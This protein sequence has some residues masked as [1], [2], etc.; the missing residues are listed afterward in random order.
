MPPVIQSVSILFVVILTVKGLNFDKYIQQ[1]YSKFTAILFNFFF[2]KAIGYSRF[3]PYYIRL[4]E[5]LCPTDFTV[6]TTESNLGLTSLISKMPDVKLKLV[7][8][9]VH[10]IVGISNSRNIVGV[11]NSVSIFLIENKTSLPLDF[12]HQYITK[13]IGTTNDIVAQSSAGEIFDMWKQFIDGGTATLESTAYRSLRKILMFVVAATISDVADKEKFLSNFTKYERKT[14]DNTPIANSMLDVF[15]SINDLIT[16]GMQYL[17]GEISFQSLLHCGSSYVEWYESS[18]R[19]IQNVNRYCTEPGYTIAKDALSSLEKAIADGNQIIA[20][21]AGT[22]NIPYIQPQIIR[23]EAAKTKLVSK[24]MM[25]SSRR[26]PLGILIH[27]PPKVGKSFTAQ[28]IRSSYKNVFKVENPD[29]ITFNKNAQDDYFTGMT[30]STKI[31]VMDDVASLNPKSNQP[32]NSLRELLNIISPLPY[33]PNMAAV[34]E[35]GTVHCLVDVVVATTNTRHLNVRDNFSNPNAFIRRFPYVIEPVVKPEFAVVNAKSVDNMI[36]SEKVQKYR[37]AHPGELFDVSLYRVC[38]PLIH[39]KVRFDDIP[40]F[41]KLLT[42]V[43][44]YQFIKEKIEGHKKEQDS[45]KEG[46]DIITC[47]ECIC[48]RSVPISICPDCH[49]IDKKLWNKTQQ[50]KNMLHFKMDN[51]YLEGVNLESYRHLYDRR[52]HVAEFNDNVAQVSKIDDS[53]K[54]KKALT[55]LGDVASSFFSHKFGTYLLSREFAVFLAFVGSSAFIYKSLYKNEQVEEAPVEIK[56]N[57]KVWEKF[58]I[59]KSDFDLTDRTIHYT[60]FFKKLSNY[61]IRIEG[62]HMGYIHGIPLKGSVYIFPLHYFDGKLE[63]KYTI[64]NY[65]GNVELKIVLT[66]GDFTI[67]KAMDLAFVKIYDVPPAPDFSKYFITESEVPQ[68][69]GYPA[70]IYIWN[71]KEEDCEIRTVNLSK[72]ENINYE[73]PSSSLKKEKST[74]ITTV[75]DGAFV[76][77]DCGSPIIIKHKNRPVIV[78]FH[79]AYSKQRKK[80]FGAILAQETFPDLSMIVAQGSSM[81]GAY[82]VYSSHTNQLHEN[83]FLNRFPKNVHQFGSIQNFARVRGKGSVQKTVIHDIVQKHW[84]LEHDEYAQPIMNPKTIDGVFQ[85]PFANGFQHCLN[86]SSPIPNDFLFDTFPIIFLKHV[87]ESIEGKFLKPLTLLEAVNGIDGHPYIKSM[88][89]STSMGYPYRGPKSNFCVLI[90][91]EDPPSF[92]QRGNVYVC[93]DDLSDNDSELS[94]CSDCGSYLGSVYSTG[95]TT[96]GYKSNDSTPPFTSSSETSDGSYEF[97]NGIPR[98]LYKPNEETIE[99]MNYMEKEYREGRRCCP[100][101]NTCLKDEALPK[102][103]QTKTRIFAASMFA[104]NLLVRKYFLPIVALM[105]EDPILWCNSVG[106]NCRGSAWKDLHNHL[107]KFGK[108][109]LI[110]GDYSKYDK[111]MAGK[112]ILAALSFLIIIAKKVGYSYD[113]LRIMRAMSYD[114]AYPLYNTNGDLHMFNGSNASGNSLTVDINCIVNV[115]YMMFAYSQFYDE[116]E[117]FEKVAPAMYGD[118]NI[119]GISRDRPNYNHTSISKFFATIGIK[120]TMADKNAISVPYRGIGDVSYLKRKFLKR[121][122]RILAPLDPESLFKSLAYRTSIKHE[123]HEHTQEVLSN[124][125]IEAYAYKDTKVRDAIDKIIEESPYDI[126][127]LSEDQLAQYYEL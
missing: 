64:T 59:P 43:E 103:K 85:D 71:N 9:L 11:I 30:S 17:S 19:Q 86:A 122:D 73:S 69:R 117:F 87:S 16:N 58:E 90:V 82:G 24:M 102:S 93:T 125:Q 115:I 79:V 88:N 7:R 57:N 116:E 123:D 32:D 52:S 99:L 60:H 48:Y 61:M 80:G 56:V 21:N 49:V 40:V 2:K 42:T 46:N 124:A 101:Y 4:Y 63:G 105:R 45:Y 89:M 20:V 36:D 8:H 107:V 108:N 114:L 44:L 51:A 112:V 13:I 54:I 96:C 95:C 33:A 120:Y 31:M 67:N 109:T 91:P 26:E 62:N 15:K 22:K 38:R 78:G 25:G 23:L 27:G 6:Y 34:E 127:R 110:D 28:L 100:V 65:H 55:S 76:G 84:P 118:D 29:D 94:G 104:F 81:V 106:M 70:N 98:P 14:Y 39:D 75:Y 92:E 53:G 119:A 18:V 72:E 77:G 10:L 35:K 74:S 113:A 97:Y 66:E 126:Y 111:T 12:V 50:I 83:S 37:D 1:L 68:I 41:D 3:Y 121:G 47:D 5:T